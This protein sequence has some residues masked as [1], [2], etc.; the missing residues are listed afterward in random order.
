MTVC[1]LYIVYIFHVHASL[2]VLRRGDKSVNQPSAWR[3]VCG[4]GAGARWAEGRPP[5]GG[6]TA[7]TRTDLWPPTRGPEDRPRPARKPGTGRRGTRLRCHLTHSRTE[8]EPHGSWSFKPWFTPSPPFTAVTRFGVKG[9]RAVRG[10]IRLSYVSEQP[11][12]DSSTHFNTY[13]T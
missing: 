6:T 5:A 2:C 12:E 10:L 11:L 9:K 1:V 7:W 3:S 13:I 8:R 4:G